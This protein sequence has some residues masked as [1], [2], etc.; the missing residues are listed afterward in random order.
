LE[1]WSCDF[2]RAR[3]VARHPEAESRE[4]QLDQNRFQR[5]LHHLTGRACGEDVEPGVAD[6]ERSG[7]RCRNFG[8]R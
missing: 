6:E 8:E 7:D 5:C 3:E 4:R 2:D 1:E